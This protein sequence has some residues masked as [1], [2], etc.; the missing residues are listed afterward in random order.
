MDYTALNPYC[1]G[2]F[3]AFWV[4]IFAAVKIFQ[5][6]HP[7]YPFGPEGQKGKLREFGF[8]DEKHE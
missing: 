5:T 7:D 8:G 6:S 2:L 1:W 4:V 3:V